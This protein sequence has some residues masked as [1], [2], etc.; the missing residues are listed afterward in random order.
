MTIYYIASSMKQKNADKRSDLNLDD[1]TI[2][3][4]KIFEYHK[5]HKISKDLM[6]NYYIFIPINDDSI[7]TVTGIR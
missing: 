7:I 4:S 3:V 2:H 1:S 5:R 6:N